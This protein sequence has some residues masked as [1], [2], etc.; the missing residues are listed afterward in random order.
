MPESRPT[1]LNTG[2]VAHAQRLIAEGKI[3]DGSP[4]HG[5]DAALGDAVI[6]REGMAAYAIWFLGTHPGT[7]PDTKEH[8]SFP[9]SDDFTH[10]N[11]EGLRAADTRAG[12]WGH[13]DIEEAAKALYQA[14]KARES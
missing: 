14:A 3:A 5:P 2:A 13:I 8:Y 11:L 12:Q 1:E 7:N 6:S 10:V 4:W 9:I